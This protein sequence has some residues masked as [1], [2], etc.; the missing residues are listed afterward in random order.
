MESKGRR[1]SGCLASWRGYRG[2][3]RGRKQALMCKTVEGE[4]N[5]KEEEKERIWVSGVMEGLQRPKKGS[6]TG[7]DE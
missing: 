3:R 6:Q 7:L 5:R 4:E 1:R 2:L